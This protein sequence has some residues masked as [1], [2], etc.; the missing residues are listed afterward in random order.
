VF[1]VFVLGVSVGRTRRRGI[2]ARDIEGEIESVD[3]VSGF[4]DHH[5]TTV[6]DGVDLANDCIVDDRLV[7]CDGGR[8]NRNV[9]PMVGGVLVGVPSIPSFE[10]V[11]QRDHKTREFQA[12]LRLRGLPEAS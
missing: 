7:Y 4:F 11:L 5:Q 6:F 10:C 12:K 9:D 2:V 8:N 3:G 1:V